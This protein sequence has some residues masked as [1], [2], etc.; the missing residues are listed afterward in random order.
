MATIQVKGSHFDTDSETVFSILWKVVQNN[1]T[2]RTYVQPFQAKPRTA[3]REASKANGRGAM[4]ALIDWCGGA[5][6]RKARSK[7]ARAVLTK[8]VWSGQPRCNFCFEDF[9]AQMKAA[10]DELSLLNEAIAEHVQVDTYLDA[11]TDPKLEVAKATVIAHDTMADS[12]AEASH[13]MANMHL[14]AS[15]TG[16][17]GSRVVAEAGDGGRKGQRKRKSKRNVPDPKRPHIHAEAT[18][19]KIGMILLKTRRT[20]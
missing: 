10:F 15:V 3:A 11:I 20:K 16:K 18:L 5:A 4:L 7:A 14:R 1:D 9:N 17:P 13:Y 8:A 19:P 12:F 2:T 6:T